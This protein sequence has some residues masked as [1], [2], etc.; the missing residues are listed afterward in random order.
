MQNYRNSNLENI[1]SEVIDTAITKFKNNKALGCD[2]FKIE[3]IKE[4]WRYKPI[5]KL[6][7]QLLRSGKVSKVME[8]VELE[9][10]TKR[11]KE[12]Q[13]SIKFL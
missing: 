12:R 13:N 1:S 5:V 3:I 11:R 8:R 2:N 7:Q 4:L 6:V 10:N 9:D